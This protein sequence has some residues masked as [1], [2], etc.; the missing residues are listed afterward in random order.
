MT[1]ARDASLSLREAVPALGLRTDYLRH[2]REAGRSVRERQCSSWVAGP[3]IYVTSARRLSP[4]ARGSAGPASPAP[5]FT[6]LLGGARGTPL[7]MPKCTV[8]YATFRIVCLISS[9]VL[10]FPTENRQTARE[11]TQNGSG[12][13]GFFDRFT[14]AAK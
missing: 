1:L 6:A 2:F 12:H 13:H 4:F 5:L 14:Q 7:G 9:I 3:F 11:P 8:I 10:V